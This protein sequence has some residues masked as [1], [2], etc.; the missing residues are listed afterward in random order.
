MKI[1][2]KKILYNNIKNNK[3][4][5][6]KLNKRNVKLLEE[7]SGVNL[8]FGFDRGYLGMTLKAQATATKVDKLD[9]TRLKTFGCNQESEKTAHRMAE[10]IYKSYI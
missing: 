10:Y 8:N 2:F 6:N 5:K 3:I 7:G 4:L 9:F 1:T